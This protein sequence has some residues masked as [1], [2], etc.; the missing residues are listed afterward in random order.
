MKFCDKAI[1]E[2]LLKGGKIKRKIYKCTLILNIGDNHMIFDNS[3]NIFKLSED[4]LIDDGWEIVEP[5]YDW[6]K[7]IKDKV[8]C[9]LSNDASFEKFIIAPLTSY[10]NESNNAYPFACF[11]IGCYKYCKPFKPAEFN[12]AKYLKAYLAESSKLGVF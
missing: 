11:Y 3:G 1:Q 6:Q 9:V 10:N 2:H 8:L 4:D 7:I 5:E 12:V